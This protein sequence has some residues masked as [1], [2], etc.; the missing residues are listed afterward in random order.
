[1]LTLLAEKIENKAKIEGKIE[2][3][4][5]TALN[6]IQDGMSIDKVV[7]YTGLDREKVEQLKIKNKV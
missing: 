7:R 6:L 2:G 5:E 1:M 4:I 3:K